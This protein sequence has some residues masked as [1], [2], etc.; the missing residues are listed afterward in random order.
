MV[1]GRLLAAAAG[2]REAGGRRRRHLPPS[3]AG[4]LLR[5]WTGFARRGSGQLPLQR[6]RVQRPRNLHPAAAGS[7][8]ARGVGRVAPDI[9]SGTDD[10]YPSI[11]DAVRRCRGAGT[12]RAAGVPVRRGLCRGRLPRRART[13]PRRRPLPADAA[14][15]L[16]PRSRSI[17][18]PLG[19]PAAAAVRADLRQET[20]VRVSAGGDRH[21]RGRRQPVPFYLQPT[22]GGGQ[23]LRSVRRL[24]L[25]RHPR[26]AG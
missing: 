7:M 3:A 5:S 1:Q 24:S 2:A 19:R 15:V 22:L 13:H 4:R 16:R 8:S 26:A 17:Q 9:R 10:R 25:P 14:E 23:S 12:E 21:R 20:G 11:E 6:H 18:L